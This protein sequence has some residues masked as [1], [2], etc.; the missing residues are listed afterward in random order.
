MI[1]VP[2]PFFLNTVLS[3]VTG[4]KFLSLL[5]YPAVMLPGPLQ[6]L[7]RTISFNTLISLL[8]AYHKDS[9]RGH[10]AKTSTLSGLR[11][12][13]STSS[14]LTAALSSSALAYLHPH[15]RSTLP[16]LFTSSSSAQR[17]GTL[18][19]NLTAAGA[20]KKTHKRRLSRA[21]SLIIPKLDDFFEPSKYE[22]RSARHACRKRTGQ[23][24]LTY[25]LVLLTTSYSYLYQ[26]AAGQRYVV[27]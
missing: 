9:Y 15:W 11:R 6:C 16:N 19:I 17:G 21:T 23:T 10:F 4:A 12:Q 1:A 7:S 2:Q 26:L 14:T 25:E 22:L 5:R 20:F 8:R 24:A 18:A 27:T 13:P 3:L